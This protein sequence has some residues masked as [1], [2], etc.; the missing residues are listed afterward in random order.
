MCGFFK[1]PPRCGT[2]NPAGVFRPPVTTGSVQAFIDVKTNIQGIPFRFQGVTPLFQTPIVNRFA[3]V[4][5]LEG[6]NNFLSVSWGIGIINRMMGFAA[7]VLL[8]GGS[9]N[10]Q[11][12]NLIYEGPENLDTRLVA[13]E[14]SDG[15]DFFRMI[16]SV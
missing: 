6:A 5:E 9:R 2:K 13:L 10:W 7:T 16:V 12:E 15:A 14:H 1:L 4:I 3:A 11:R 8:Q